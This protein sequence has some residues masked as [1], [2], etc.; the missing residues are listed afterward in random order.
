[1]NKV[2]AAEAFATYRAAVELCRST[3]ARN[4]SIVGEYG[5]HLAAQAL[6]GTLAPVSN[7]GIDLVVDGVTYQVKTRCGNPQ[8][9]AITSWDF[10]YLIGIHL[11]RE[12]IL[13]LAVRIPVDACRQLI[14]PKK[15]CILLNLALLN[16]PGVENITGLFTKAINNE[17]EAS[18]EETPLT[19]PQRETA[20]RTLGS[21]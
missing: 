5:E 19:E 7:K 4:E 10:D 16:K 12:G 2:T 21:V 9:G 6:G 13:D 14:N 18:A 15:R 3:F 11:T 8:S 17:K 1:M 20:T